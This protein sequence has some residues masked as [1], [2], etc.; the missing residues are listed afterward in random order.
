MLTPAQATEKEESLAQ[1]A[2][3]DEEDN[4]PMVIGENS[5]SFANDSFGEGASAKSDAALG[6]LTPSEKIEP[7]RDGKKPAPPKKVK[8]ASTSRTKQAGGE[9]DDPIAQLTRQRLDEAAKRDSPGRLHCAD[10][11]EHQVPGSLEQ[12]RL[13]RHAQWNS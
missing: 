12:R 2:I 3:M 9:A 4:R 6:D 8:M 5:Q 13:V 1:N 10:G 11:R 7:Q